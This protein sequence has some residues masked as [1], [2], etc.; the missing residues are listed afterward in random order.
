[1]Q[2]KL[3]VLIAGVEAEL[4]GQLTQAL[5][6]QGYHIITAESGSTAVSMALSHCPDCVLLQH[7]LLD[8]S[9]L[10]ALQAIRKWSSVPVLILSAN[11]SE[12]E[13]IHALQL[14]ADDYLPEPFSLP[15][16]LAHIQTAFRHSEKAG[17]AGLSADVLQAGPV[18]VDLCQRSVTVRGQKTHLT[19]NEYKIFLLLVQNPGRVL[20]YSDLI[21]A[22]W[23]HFAA[24]D[25]QILRV[26]IANIRKKIEIDPANPRIIVTEI[27]VGYRFSI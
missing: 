12:S 15:K 2:N 20:L 10:D 27:G 8:S 4:S 22:V 17:T 24:D 1:M 7:P 18:S 5:T 16:L 11:G 13:E 23:G 19:Q 21:E 3:T 25:R 14:G 26:N 9:G 6:S